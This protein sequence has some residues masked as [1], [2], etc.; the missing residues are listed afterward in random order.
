MEEVV[1]PDDDGNGITLGFIGTD[2][3]FVNPVDH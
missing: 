1:I 3:E 2:V